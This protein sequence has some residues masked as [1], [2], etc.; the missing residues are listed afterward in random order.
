[1]DRGERRESRF[2]RGR[3]GGFTDGGERSGYT[4]IRSAHI[5]VIRKII[6]QRG[7]AGRTTFLFHYGWGGGYRSC[8]GRWNFYRCDSLQGRTAFVAKN[9]LFIEKFCSASWTDNVHF[10]RD[11]RR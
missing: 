1:M 2:F 4:N 3:L 7:T 11:N 8:A 5:A 9:G 6:H 10:F